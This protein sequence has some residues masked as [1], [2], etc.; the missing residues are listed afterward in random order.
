M[1]A[2][3]QVPFY[4]EPSEGYKNYREVLPLESRHPVGK[5]YRTS[6]EN[7]W[8]VSE[9][10]T[11]ILIVSQV[12]IFNVKISVNTYVQRAVLSMMN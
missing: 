8:K 4:S 9:D 2:V 11:Y 12:F 1:R 6:L 3:K 10:L 5:K 7:E